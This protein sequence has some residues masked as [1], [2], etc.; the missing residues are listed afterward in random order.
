MLACLGW[1]AVFVLVLALR[2]HISLVADAEHEL[3]G[4]ATALGFAAERM[5]RAGATRAFAPLVAL[6][7]ERIG[8]GLADLE[9]SR[10]RTVPLRRWDLHFA[11]LTYLRRPH[12][13]E[14]RPARP[15]AS[16]APGAVDAGRLTQV[17]ANLVANAVEHGRGPVQVSWSPT[18]AGGRLEIRNPNRPPELND[19]VVERHAR[20]RGL[21]IAR[22]AARA[23]GGGLRL[24][25]SEEETIAT[26]DLRTPGSEHSKGPTKP[27]DE[28]S[29]RAA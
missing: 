28:T 9:R 2:R 6:Q 15:P 24:E 13:L 22:R 21:S 14:R 1:G 8:A 18:P 12:F 26:V 25:A 23:L 7:L 4:A 17:V 3:R 5:R 10:R 20:G 19:L 27:P 29:A 11:R 16:N